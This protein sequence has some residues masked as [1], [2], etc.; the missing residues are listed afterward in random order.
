MA[1]ERS[2]FGDGSDTGAGNVTT[3]VTNHFGQRDFGNTQGVAKVEGHVSQAVLHFDGD[4]LSAE[5][6]PLNALPPKLPA[7]VVIKSAYVYV[8]EAFVLGGTSPV[9]ELGTEGSEATNGVS[10]TEAQLE[11]VGIYDVTAAISGTWGAPLGA[12]TVV[13]IDFA[14]TNPTTTSAGKARV[15][16]EF[17]DIG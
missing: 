7:N 17:V 5:A 16:I 15:L 10:I 11:A 13:G 9:V 14:G 12:E 8:D 3:Q 6:F 2:K 4:I 1:Y